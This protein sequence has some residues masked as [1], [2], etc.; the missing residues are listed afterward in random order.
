MR[1]GPTQRDGD[2]AKKRRSEPAPAR[3][4]GRG[5]AQ[6]A[7]I[8]AGALTLLAALGCAHVE[9]QFRED[10]PSVAADWN[11]PTAADVYARFQPA[12]GRQRAVT[13]KLTQSARGAVT[14]GP[15]YFQD[16]F[17]DKGS[18]HADFR[19]GWEDAVA[20]PYGYA[21][22]TLNW[23]L[24]PASMVVEPP[25]KELESDGILS[26]QALGYDHDPEPTAAHAEPQVPPAA[27]TQE[28]P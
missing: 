11:S 14:H 9:N 16:P 7:A 22:Y 19:I 20:T 28:A 23:L 5:G 13:P 12:A 15:L 24:L 27:E 26:R 2:A 25:W 8:V 6:R 21:R 17:E 18:G 3:G 4:W 10:G 1:D